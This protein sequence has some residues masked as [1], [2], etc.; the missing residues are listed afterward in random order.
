M[1][2]ENWH[3][4]K[5]SPW[6]NKIFR[7]IVKMSVSP[8]ADCP[9]K[10]NAADY[11]VM[12]SLLVKDLKNNNN[13]VEK[14]KLVN[15]ATT[16][17]FFPSVSQLPYPAWRDDPWGLAGFENKMASPWCVVS[18]PLPYILIKQIMLPQSSLCS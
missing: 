13:K 9:Y 14:Q 3:L 10:E 7:W 2:L 16:M 11:F 8:F 17:A 5:K 18:M 4:K 1:S 12:N 6:N 15:I